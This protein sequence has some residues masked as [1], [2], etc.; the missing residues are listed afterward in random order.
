MGVTE[1]Q[2]GEPYDHPVVLP[3]QT[4]FPQKSGAEAPHGFW[5]LIELARIKSIKGREKPF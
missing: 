4:R 2:R 3:L 1:T 5:Q